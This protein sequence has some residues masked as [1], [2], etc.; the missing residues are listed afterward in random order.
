MAKVVD[1]DERR[2]EILQKSLGLFARM[3]YPQVTYQQ[4]AESCGLTRTALY[5]YFKNK[6]DV[7]DNALYQL[8]QNINMQL[9]EKIQ[10]NPALK[11]SEKLEM[12]LSE[13][14]DLCLSNPALMHAIVEYLI[15]QKR[16]GQSVE[17]KIKRHIIGFQRFIQHLVMEGIESGEFSKEIKPS[18]VEDMLMGLIQAVCLRIMFY[19]DANRE[20]LLKH[21]RIIIS[22]IQN[23]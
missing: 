17:K 8:V 7:F 15:A 20:K 4:L 16:Q 3:G 22:A 12:L 1:H 2:R 18:E 11:S 5:K 13:A 23:D 21:C 6:R 19:D 10:A 9:H 14:V